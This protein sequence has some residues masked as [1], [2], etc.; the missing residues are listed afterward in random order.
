MSNS[1]LNQARTK[2]QDASVHPIAISVF[3]QLYK[4]LEKDTDGYIRESDITPLTEVAT[5]GDLDSA[6]ELATQLQTQDPDPL[7][8]DVPKLGQPAGAIGATA[9]VKL[10]G[11]LGTS[12]GMSQAKSLLPVHKG[13]SFLDIIA[14][15]VR[16]ARARYDISLPIIFMNSF[17]TED[18]TLAALAKYP[19]LEVSGIS[20]S[21]MQNQEPKLRADDLTPVQ[22]P[23]NPD[24]E[25]CPPGHGDVYTVLQTSG[26][27]DALE[28]AGYKYLNISNADNLGSAPN[29]QIAQWFEDSGASFAAEVVQK[30][31]ADRKG[32]A[33]VVRDGQIIQRE[34][35]QIAPED[36]EVA[37][38]I[39]IHRFFNANNLWIKISA[40]K[41]LI[42]KKDGVV[43]LPL[44]KNY[45]TVDP[46]DKTSTPVVQI[47]CAMAAA[48]ELFEDAV[49]VHIDRSRFLPVK[50]TNDLLLLRSDI[51]SLT[52]SFQ[53]RAQATE[54]L[55]TLDPAHYALIKEFDQRFPAGPPELLLARTLT[56]KGDWTFGSDTAAVGDA[57]LE[58]DSEQGP[59]SVPSGSTITYQGV[60]KK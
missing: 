53:L 50:T 10:N 38:D 15:Q 56:V 47:E 45:K 49:A 43:A 32:G 28:A 55:I 17:R 26:T 46:T 59:Q 58:T 54:P 2:M 27:L 20:L 21:M 40:L 36:M 25:W 16:W 41:E 18:D 51:Y 12:M 31:E 33:Q 14:G 1:G 8:I 39:T 57:L 44:I 30:T 13:L 37:S 60:V 34:T 42:A 24:L 52:N 29:P 4:Q 23:A 3:E 19:D 9:L 6:D 35:A 7:N 5:L 22:W 11:G 48:I